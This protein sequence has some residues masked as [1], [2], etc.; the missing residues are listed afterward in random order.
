MAGFGSVEFI[1]WGFFIIITVL[2][3]ILPAIVYFLTMCPTISSGDSAELITN[4]YQ[5]GLTHPPGY[6]LYTFVAKLFTYIPYNTIAWRVNLFSVTAMALSVSFLYLSLNRLIK[7]SWVSLLLAL[8]Y[9][10]SSLVWRYALVAEVFALNQLFLSLFLY[11]TLA[12]WQTKSLKYFLLMSLVTGLALAHHHTF[13]FIS[14]PLF[15]WAGLFLKKELNFIILLKAAVVF[16]VGIS[17]YVLLFVIGNRGTLLSWGAI[18]DFSDLF[19]HILRLDYGLLSLGPQY[20]GSYFLK[21]I[22]EFFI[23]T[24]SE[25]LFVL[26]PLL[27]Y[28][29]RRQLKN[30][31]WLSPFFWIMIAL[32]GYI[33]IFHSLAEINI[34]DPIY[35]SVLQRFW[36]MPYML[37]FVLAAWNFEF[38]YVAVFTKNK[39]QISIAILSVLVLV[40]FAKNYQRADQ[41]KNWLYHDFA[42]IL[43][44]GVDDQG[45]LLVY[46][47][48]D[49]FTATYM[50][51]CERLRPDV[52]IVSQA[53]LSYPWYAKILKTKYPELNFQMQVPA[54][55]QQVSMF[56]LENIVRHAI[57]T[58]PS[59]PLMTEDWRKY[60]YELPVGFANK[61]VWVGTKPTLA[62]Y[63]NSYGKIWNDYS[64]LEFAIQQKLD[65]DI[66]V[67]QRFYN[68]EY[69]RFDF[70]MENYSTIDTTQQDDLKLGLKR[71][72]K[73]YDGDAKLNGWWTTL[74]SG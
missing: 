72:M 9:G 36:L 55:N 31:N 24:Q 58:G 74:N 5:L 6:P 28:F 30:V 62:E 67:I 23:T 11:L 17:P 47:D 59:S 73:Y 4:A 45:I 65:W 70:I 26:F 16:I 49:V 51:V 40:Q 64:W 13:I 54:G 50:Q 41:S 68:S 32:I 18:L 61:L 33:I 63:I 15:A 48:L 38:L 1:E 34:K 69:R 66:H 27:F 14:L 56:I 43:L 20:G 60:Y 39:S 57:F 37:L 25:S 35:L 22:A 29:G 44:S 52:K 19:H 21:N 7:R 12:L 42:K 10:F 46:G 71:L 2:S 3:F 53:R 8:L